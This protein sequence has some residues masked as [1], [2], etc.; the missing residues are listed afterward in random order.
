MSAGDAYDWPPGWCALLPE[1]A[2]VFLAQLRRELAPDH[3]LQRL[4]V[5]AI[6]VA[7][8]SDDAVFAVDG[9]QA[10]FCVVHLSWPGPDPRPW[11]LRQLRPWPRHDPAI[12]PLADLS[13]LPAD[14]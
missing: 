9:W 6:G 14:T 4:P 2:P 3:P 5:R 10:P 11:L 12:L 7:L 8:G 13:A 1:Q